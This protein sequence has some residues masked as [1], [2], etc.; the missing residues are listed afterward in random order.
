M[1]LLR[2]DCLV[3]KTS[4]GQHLPCSAH[5]IATKLMGDSAQ[6]LHPELVE[7]A[8]AAILHYFKSEKGQH[9]VSVAEF[10]GALRRV[11]RGLGFDVKTS[12]S[13]PGWEGASQA[14]AK[15]RVIEANLQQLADVSS[16]GCELLFFPRL[17]DAVRRQLDGTPLVLQFRGLRPCV[18]Q[19]TGA[20][21]WGARCQQLN[22]QIVE[23]LRTCLT[24]EKSGDGCALVVW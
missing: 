17:R 6:W 15:R 4:G 1:I 9:F 14:S 10:C 18:K 12:D 22:D 8:A 3:F 2:P 24:A 11:L 19:L 13:A 21:R 7:H 16:Q 20:K 5:E 23:Y